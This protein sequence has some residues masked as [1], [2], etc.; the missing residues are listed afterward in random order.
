MIS[1][2]VLGFLVFSV[3]NQ[4]FAQAPESLESTLNEEII[5]IPSGWSKLKT[6]VMRPDGAGP[7]PLIVMNH[8]KAFGNP[9]FQS[10]SRFLTLSS[11]MVRMG[12]A[13]IL[14][15][16]KGVAGSGGTYIGS[17]GGGACAMTWMGKAQ[18]EDIAAT[19][20]FAIKLPY[21]DISKI[22]VVGQSHGG[23]AALAFAAQPAV[24]GVRAVVN[25]AG[26]NKS[27]DCLG[28]EN[29][30]RNAFGEWGKTATYPTLWFYGENDS[31]FP[32]PVYRPAHTAYV[33]HGA[34]A[35]LVEFGVFA[36]GDAHAMI[37]QSQGVPI[38]LPRI[39]TF[40]RSLGLPS[41]ATYI[42]SQEAIP[43]ESGFAQSSDVEAV[44][45][46]SSQGKENYRK[47][48]AFPGGKAFVLTPSGRHWW[49]FGGADPVWRAL[50]N[51]RKEISDGCAL[52]AV[53][54]RVVW[55]K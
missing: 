37:G 31:F 11:E 13:V 28:W 10:R 5:E 20:E 21:I 46:L 18:A 45:S 40:F 53:N 15:N 41:E 23:M 19:I 51:C 24:P 52:Y 33:A 44:P 55:S 4:L 32:P 22:V 54:E 35:D 34:K 29:N 43:A 3:A 48:L 38:W 42:K 7:F 25:F 49:A 50:T 27:P 8:G 2:L 12:Y 6:T 16:R 26:G 14:P 47:Y 30:M 9:Y 17:E 1:R 39:R 36:A